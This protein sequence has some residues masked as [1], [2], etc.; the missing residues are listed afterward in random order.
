LDGTQFF[1]LILAPVG[2]KITDRF[3][4]KPFQ[5]CPISMTFVLKNI[6]ILPVG[7]EAIEKGLY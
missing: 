3:W 5:L 2:E 1:Y 7:L 6:D 4:V